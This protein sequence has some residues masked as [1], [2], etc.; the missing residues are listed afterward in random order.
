MAREH[1][2]RQPTLDLLTER[3]VDARD[4]LDGE[5]K[6]FAVTCK[7]PN[8]RETR[9]EARLWTDVAHQEELVVMTGPCEHP[10]RADGQRIGA[11][12]HH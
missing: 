6:L 2:G 10:L 5:Q 4:T 3:T 12:T 11:A 7:E 1:D 8:H 9:H